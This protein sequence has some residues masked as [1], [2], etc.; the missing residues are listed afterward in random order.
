M[1][2]ANR[3]P[4]L[5]PGAGINVIKLDIERTRDELAATLDDLFAT[6]NL[7]VQIRS[8]PG[9]F[10]GVFLLIAAAAAGLVVLRTRK[11]SRG[12]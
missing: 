12:R 11:S 7:R 4:P 10:T 9:V 1:T 6:F 8:N 2:D 3:R 5:A